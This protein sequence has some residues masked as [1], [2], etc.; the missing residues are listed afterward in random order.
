MHSK[1]VRGTRKL[2]CKS[3][4]VINLIKTKFEL[5]EILIFMINIK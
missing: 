2:L 3:K 1:F 5:N 4:H